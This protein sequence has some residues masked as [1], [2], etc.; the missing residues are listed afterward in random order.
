MQV[1]ISEFLKREFRFLHV[2]KAAGHLW[3]QSTTVIVE[4]T[5]LVEQKTLTAQFYLLLVES[6]I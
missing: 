2:L 5:G 6:P 3:I 4:T 1:S